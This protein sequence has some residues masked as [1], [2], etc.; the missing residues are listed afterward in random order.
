MNNSFL[1]KLESLLYSKYST[2]EKGNILIY[3]N[4]LSD[5]L[6]MVFRDENKKA[7]QSEEIWMG[8]KKS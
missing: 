2:N 5:Y 1:D 8:K 4:R 3:F 6:F 7:K